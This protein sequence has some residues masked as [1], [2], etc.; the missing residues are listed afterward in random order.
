MAADRRRRFSRGGQRSP[1]SG[2]LPP[3]GAPAR[4]LVPVR[5]HL[6]PPAPTPHREG[7]VVA[8]ECTR[9]LSCAAARLRVHSSSTELPRRQRPPS[10]ARASGR[11]P[12]GTLLLATSQGASARGP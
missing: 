1:Q 11:V 7:A 6:R 4:A 12:G 2:G 5:V 9:N 3:A 8:D 10:V